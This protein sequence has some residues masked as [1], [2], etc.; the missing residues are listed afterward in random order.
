MFYVFYHNFHARGAVHVVNL[1]KHTSIESVKHPAILSS[2]IPFSS[3]LQSFP[4]SG[5]FLMSQLSASGGHRSFSASISPSN[6]YSGLISFR[7]DWFD[8]LAVGGTLESLLQ[9]RNSKASILWCSAF[10]MVQL[11]HPLKKIIYSFRCIRSFV[12][13]SCTWA[14]L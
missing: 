10:F 1:L 4:A 8:L 12:I 5:S 3:C 9:H 14:P 7:I 11:S 6:Q 13:F 2:V